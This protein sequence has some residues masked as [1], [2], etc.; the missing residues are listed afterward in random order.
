MSTDKYILDAHGTPQREPDLL[1]WVRWIE[2]SHRIVRQ[3]RVGAVN[4]ST[5][6]LG[7]D[8][9]F[10]NGP[11]VLY[12]TMVFGGPLDREEDRYSTRDEA[13]AGHARMVARVK[14]VLA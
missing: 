2:T 14:D 1:T 7:L 9:Q 12:E 4:V 6:F 10:G 11:P 3:E 8:H 5:V 13:L